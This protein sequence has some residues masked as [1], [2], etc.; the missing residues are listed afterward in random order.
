MQ[1]LLNRL[2]YILISL[3]C[4][5][6]RQMNKP[7][8]I[9]FSLISGAVFVVIG[10][11]IANDW[12]GGFNDIFGTQKFEFAQAKAILAVIDGILF[13]LDGLFTSFC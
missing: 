12:H 4:C 13:L 10:V 5:C 11:L 1:I 6:D 2:L 8:D 9:V 3:D 7:T